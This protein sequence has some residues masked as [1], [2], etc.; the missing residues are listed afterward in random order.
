MAIPAKVIV[1]VLGI[2]AALGLVWFGIQQL[3][4]DD[5]MCMDHALRPGEFCDTTSGELVHRSYEQ[6][7]ALQHTGGIV[8]LTIGVLL[9]PVSALLLWYHPRTTPR[10]VHRRRRII[11]VALA[12]LGLA[13]VAI[14][15]LL[16]ASDVTC[17]DRL[18][19]AGGTCQVVDDG[20]VTTETYATRQETQRIE[21]AV[22][23][24]VGIVLVAYCVR[25]WRKPNP[26]TLPPLPTA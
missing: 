25:L 22:A 5:V 9:L 21:G 13:L 15:G 10:A 17:A 24:V 12:A 7:H 20:R 4:A 14:G 3:T 23:A 18:M 8:A 26:S 2:L 6:M 1:G 16:A 19:R 11:A